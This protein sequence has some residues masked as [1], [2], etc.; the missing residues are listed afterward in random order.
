MLSAHASY[1]ASVCRSFYV[2]TAAFGL[3]TCSQ[4]LLFGFSLGKKDCL[5][6]WPVYLAMPYRFLFEFRALNCNGSS[7]FV[8]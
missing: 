3:S 1:A 4:L 6:F 8:R 7:M 2:A 5:I